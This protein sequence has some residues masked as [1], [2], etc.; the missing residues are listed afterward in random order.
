MLKQITIRN[1]ALIDEMSVAFGP[2]LTVEMATVD[3]IFDP[4]SAGVASVAAVLL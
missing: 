1:Y 2:G 3:A 4:I